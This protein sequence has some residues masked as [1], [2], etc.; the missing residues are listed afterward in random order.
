[1]RIL[2]DAPSR[3]ASRFFM[4]IKLFGKPMND[5]KA[6]ALHAFREGRRGTLSEAVKK[7]LILLGDLVV[8]SFFEKMQSQRSDEPKEETND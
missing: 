5:A 8:A 4:A 3:S 2:R 7:D 6:K 1:M